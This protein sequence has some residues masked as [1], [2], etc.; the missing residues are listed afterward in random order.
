MATID[1]NTDNLIKFSKKLD[2]LSRSA[3]PVAVRQT[4]NSV[5]FETK[6]KTLPREAAKSF[7][8]RNPSFY[9]RFSR[10]E[11]AQGFDINRMQ[12]KA[13]M[14]DSAGG[15]KEQAGEDQTQQQIGGNI[16]GRTFIPLDQ[17]RTG[18]KHSKNVK[19]KNRISN[20]NIVLDTKDSKA[21][22]PTKKLIQ[23][24][25]QA[26][27]KFGSGSVIKH[28]GDKSEILYR[29]QRGSGIKTREFNIKL[30][31][32]Y[33]VKKGRSVRIK[34]PIPFTLNAGKRAQ[35]QANKFFRSHAK[36]ALNKV[37]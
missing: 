16:S 33:T 19:K 9:K 24:S 21:S 4:L 5:A 6:K 27:K 35:L 3:L 2:K 1:V 34:N 36:R 18:G 26:I 20:I 31:P 12:S 10:V 22:T 13:G 28:K 37:R 15:K 11:T 30:I 7:E 8:N 29:V 14:V 17:A 32:L 25:I 23:T